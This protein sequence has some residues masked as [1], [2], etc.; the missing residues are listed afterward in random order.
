MAGGRGHG[1]QHHGLLHEGVD[2]CGRA[3][4]WLAKSSRFLAHVD[5]G[6]G[7]PFTRV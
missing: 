5:V 7:T 1:N 6:T 4:V 3:V 2:G